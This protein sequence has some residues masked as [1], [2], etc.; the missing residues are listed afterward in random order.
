MSPSIATNLISDNST[1]QFEEEEMKP[2]YCLIKM[3]ILFNVSH[4]FYNLKLSDNLPTS[5]DEQTTDL[6]INAQNNNKTSRNYVLFGIF[7]A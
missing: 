1:A 6:D 4:L 5:V 3:F 2:K 7:I